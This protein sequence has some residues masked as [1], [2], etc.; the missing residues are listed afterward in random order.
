MSSNVDDTNHT[1][2][3]NSNQTVYSKDFD[4]T[5]EQKLTQ[6]GMKIVSLPSEIEDCNMV[7]TMSSNVDDTNHSAEDNSNQTVYSKDFDATV[8]QKH[9][10]CKDEPEEVEDS[11]QI[12]IVKADP[13][14]KTHVK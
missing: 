11:V 7:K 14:I 12:N 8:E 6:H 2:E 10:D 9:S 13:P 4:A 1:A 5:V 3:D